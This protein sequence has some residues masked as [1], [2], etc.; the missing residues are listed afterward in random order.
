MV[1]EHKRLWG[2]DCALVAKPLNAKCPLVTSQ[3]D[4]LCVIRQHLLLEMLLVRTDRIDSW[5]RWTMKQ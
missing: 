5:P 4:G 2:G 3:V 1:G